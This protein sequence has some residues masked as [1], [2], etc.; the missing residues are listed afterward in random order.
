M[1]NSDLIFAKEDLAVGSKNLALNPW[2]I[3]I[4]DDDPFVH[5][6]TT[7]VLENFIFDNR[8]LVF[9]NAYSSRQALELLGKNQ[10]TALLLVDVVM[11]TENAGLDLVHHVRT[12]MNNHLIQ[13]AIRT[14]QPGQAPESQVV[15]RYQVDTYNS[16]TEMTAQKLISLVTISL[17]TYRL[18]KSLDQELEK[19]KKAEINLQLLNLELEK[20]VEKRTRE[21]EESNKKL[22][23]MAQKAQ[24]ATQA[25]SEFLANM[26]HEIRTPMNAIVGMATMLLDEHLSPT[27]RQYT[28]IISSSAEAL[29]SIIND[30]LDFS[31]IE[32]RELKLENRRFSPAQTLE[33][34]RALMKVKTDKKG[35]TLSTHIRDNIPQFLMGD[36]GKI[37]Q[38]LINLTD[39]AIKFTKKGKVTIT[40]SMEACSKTRAQLIYEIRDTGPGIPE[41]FMERLFDK[42]SQADTSITR[43]YGG[44]GLGLAISK[45]LAEMMKGKIEVKSDPG[46]GSIF[47]V[48][49]NL[50]RYTEKPLEKKAELYKNIAPSFDPEK[51][52]ILLA[53]D[54]P[55]N[56][57]VALIML[58]KYGFS[59]TVVSNGLQVLNTLKNEPYDLVLMDV[60][61]P[62]MD[63]IEASRRIREQAWNTGNRDIPI[64]AMTAHAMK[65]DQDRCLAAGMNL[66]ISKPVD[67]EKLINMI[68]CAMENSKK[69]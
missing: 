1:G 21:L 14:G 2:K 15:S 58:K 7:R 61:M 66:F 12:I 6:I 65:E 60:Q 11:E 26:S 48:F 20:R 5:D 16:K 23:A 37:R 30:I 63:G 17:R 29:L 35:L 3:M 51:V 54:N 46:K 55:V 42:F 39:N 38:I 4:I 67:P 22:M 64:I 28:E 24:K 34:I 52:R 33:S 50:D 41:E 40:L 49:L 47:R 56:Q 13:I 53:E 18:S 9:L 44:T 19:R 68:Q 8:G 31:K 45:S 62:E 57:K 10:D 36:E 32:A 25:K 43:T 69:H 27:Q 59:A